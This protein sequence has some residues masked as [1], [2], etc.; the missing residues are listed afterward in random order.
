VFVYGRP[1]A[2]AR[3][4]GMI[5]YLSQRTECEVRFPLSVRQVVALGAG[6]RTPAWRGLSSAARADVERCLT[7]VGADEFAD[8][9]I[10]RLSGGQWQRALIARA[11]AANPKIL[12][13]DEPTVG[14]DAP[15][16]RRF[17]E[18][19]TR[20]HRELGVT[21]L[22]VSHNLRAIAAGCDRVACLAR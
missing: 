18:M 6:W 2:Q 12:V 3:R 13:L 8:R 11:L 14:I 7:L 4:E 20:V 16:Q 5:G 1:P 19:L 9:P 21:I 17:A 22:I 15:G 10:G